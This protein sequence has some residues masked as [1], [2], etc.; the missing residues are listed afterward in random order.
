MIRAEIDETELD[1][2]FPYCFEEGE[3]GCIPNASHVSQV[4]VEERAGEEP[5]EGDW[6]RR[7]QYMVKTLPL[8][9]EESQKKEK[10]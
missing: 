7:E 6:R 10:D 9:E 5:W 1:S 4:Q 2:G 8:L 3:R